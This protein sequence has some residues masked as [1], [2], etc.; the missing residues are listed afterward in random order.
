MK[1][2]ESNYDAIPYI[3]LPRYLQV[4]R[5]AF[6]D[7]VDSSNYHK[8]HVLGGWRYSDNDTQGGK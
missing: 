8:T 2:R 7:R 4:T 5:V 3:Q 1:G 6:L